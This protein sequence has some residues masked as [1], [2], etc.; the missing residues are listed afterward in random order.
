MTKEFTYVKRYK[1][2]L[3]E[4]CR[5]CGRK[6]TVE[7]NRDITG[8]KWRVAYC[9]EHADLII[10]DRTVGEGHVQMGDGDA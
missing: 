1:R 5:H 4:N 3:A 7:A 2:P 10:S 9:A 8:F 6:A